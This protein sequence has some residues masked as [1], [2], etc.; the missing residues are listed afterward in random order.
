[1]IRPGP[2]DN[3]VTPRA[4]ALAALEIIK[5][6]LAERIAFFPVLLGTLLCPRGLRTHGIRVNK[7]IENYSV[8]NITPRVIH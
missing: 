5:V 6:E 4:A 8:A 2:F 7:S 3:D 1:L